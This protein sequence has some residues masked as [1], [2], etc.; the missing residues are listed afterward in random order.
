MTTNVTR[1]GAW[2]DFVPED[3]SSASPGS[4]SFDVA[5][6]AVLSD[7]RRITLHSGQRG[8]SSSGP[9]RPSEGHP[10]AGMTAEEIAASVLTTV[11]PDEDDGEEHPWECLAQVLRARGVSVAADSL[12]AVP[13]AME[14]S[15]RLTELLANGPGRTCE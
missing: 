6:F 10:L 7:G 4:V 8:F 3:K 9:R 1:L 13:Y 12:K 5:E 11:L 14:F 15:E 2:C